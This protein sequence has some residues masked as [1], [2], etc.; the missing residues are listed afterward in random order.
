MARAGCFAEMTMN[1]QESTM[2]AVAPGR[3]GW[4]S[5]L[6]SYRVLQWQGLRV[7]LLTAL[8]LL[9]RLVPPRHAFE[10]VANY[11]WLHLTLE[12]LSILVAGMVFGVAWNAYSSERAGNVVILALGLLA[13][14]IIDFMHAL[15]FKGMPDFVTPSDPEKAINF[16]LAVRFTF[17]VCLPRWPGGAGRRCATPRCVLRDSPQPWRWRPS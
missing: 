6:A 11:A 15:S 2:T 12:T 3:R 10:G 17:A 1:R 8:F 7:F 5:L 13:T 9:I 4:D 16:W 14:G